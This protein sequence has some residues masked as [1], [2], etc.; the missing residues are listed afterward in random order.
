MKSHQLKIGTPGS[1]GMLA[2]A[3]T[4]STAGKPITTGLPQQQVGNNLRNE[5][6]ARN[7]S[8]SR[9]TSN[10][11]SSGTKRTPATQ[12]RVRNV[13]HCNVILLPSHHL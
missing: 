1:A 10:S 6:I 13:L 2:T 3:I 11:N 5:G 4:P 9:E 12:V 8:N 7:A